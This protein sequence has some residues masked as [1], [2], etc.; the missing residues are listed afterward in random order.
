MSVVTEY[1][2]ARGVP[3]EVIEHPRAFTSVAEARALGVEADEVLKTVVV[4]TDSGHVLVVI[5]GGHRVDMKAVREALGDP[6]AHL[7]T[8][9]ELEDD[10]ADFELGALPPL[11][12][13]L[14]ANTYV[15]P[16]VLRHETVVFAAGTQTQSVKV[17]TPDLFRAEP[18][19]YVPV[20]KEPE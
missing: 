17:H 18:V 11:G 5:P 4:D 15:D 20:A 16:D 13:L 7:A 14:K 2:E 6:H 19:R 12:S 1:L 9:L 3:F 10:F 8:E